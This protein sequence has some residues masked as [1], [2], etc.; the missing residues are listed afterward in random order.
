MT[1]D[2]IFK[3]IRNFHFFSTKCHG[4]NVAKIFHLIADVAF[5]LLTCY[6]HYT[7]VEKKLKIRSRIGQIIIKFLEYNKYEYDLVRY[8]NTSLIFHNQLIN[9]TGYQDRLTVIYLI[10]FCNNNKSNLF[11][12]QIRLFLCLHVDKNDTSVIKI[13]SQQRRQCLTKKFDDIFS[14]QN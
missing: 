13:I 4:V 8:V 7:R 14:F 3:S 5:L 1:F 10:S 12:G 9:L 2:T 6:F 11:S